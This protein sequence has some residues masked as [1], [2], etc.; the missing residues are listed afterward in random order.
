MW[1]PNGITLSYPSCC[2]PTSRDID[3]S[4]GIVTWILGELAFAKNRVRCLG[5]Y[6]IVTGPSNV[7]GGGVEGVRSISPV[8]LFDT[9]N[10]SPPGALGTL[11]I[12]SIAWGQWAKATEVLTVPAVSLGAG[13]TCS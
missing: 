13:S 1:R 5:K 11:W 3:R 7:L 12:C 10:R 2:P 9:P 6:Q 8:A 4:T